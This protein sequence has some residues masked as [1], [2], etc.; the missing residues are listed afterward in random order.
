MSEQLIIREGDLK[1]YQTVDG[2]EI[3][4]S[5]GEPEME[6]GLFTSVF[7]SLFESD[8]T[9]YWMNGFLEESEKVEGRFYSYIKGQSKTPSTMQRA[10]ELAKL[11]LD[12]MIKNK[13]ADEINVDISSIDVKRISL[14]IEIVKNSFTILESKFDINWSYTAEAV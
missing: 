8:T 11:D 6:G 14:K 10:I 4:V 3:V 1:L 5:F 9:D 7:I 2:G 12:W 13:I